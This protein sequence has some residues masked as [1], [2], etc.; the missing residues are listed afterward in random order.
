MLAAQVA[1]MKRTH[2]NLVV[3]VLAFAAFLI[4][5]STGVLLRL[6]LPPG[7]GGLVGRGSGHGVGQQTVLTLWGWSRHDWGAFHYWVACALMAILA[8]HLFLHWKWIV[9]VV[10]GKAIDQS[11]LRLG[12]GVF[13]LVALVLLTIAPWMSPIYQQ[14]REELL[15]EQILSAPVET[16]STQLRGSMTLEDVANLAEVSVDELVARLD[17]PPDV[18]PTERVGRLFRAQGKQMN[19]LRTAVHE[20]IV[21]HGEKE[22]ID[23][24]M[25]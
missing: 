11:G 16:V 21:S 17:L 4:L 19:D 5:A 24:V 13:G 23:E 12:L 2:V 3:D 20:I 15:E 22:Q 14:S 25:P 1:T 10:R 8:V 6:Q 18:S 7:S 9:C